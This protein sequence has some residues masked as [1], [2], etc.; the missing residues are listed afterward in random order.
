MSATD[1]QRETVLK[2]QTPALDTDRDSSGLYCPRCRHLPDVT[3]SYNIGSGR[4]TSIKATEARRNGGK[5]LSHGDTASRGLVPMATPGV[6]PLPYTLALA[7]SPPTKQQKRGDC[8]EVSP[9]SLACSSSHPTS[10]QG[11]C[12]RSVPD[13][14]PS[15]VF[16]P[17]HRILMPVATTP[18]DTA[19]CPVFGS[20]FSNSLG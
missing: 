20:A 3:E 11:N 5:W 6:S 1:I 14:A 2:G 7:F 10:T 19:G 13:H 4:G 9:S 15:K 8:I 12:H 18:S 17:P 16:S